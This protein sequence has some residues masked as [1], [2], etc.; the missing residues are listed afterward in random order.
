VGVRPED[1]VELIRSEATKI[2]QASPQRSESECA[3]LIALKLASEK[4]ALEKEYRQNIN[5][6]ENSVSDALEFVEQ[7][8][9][10]TA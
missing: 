8:S 4:M 6:L 7:V 1:V 3:V 2:K 10:T 5:K 9:P